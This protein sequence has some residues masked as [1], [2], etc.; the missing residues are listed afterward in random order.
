[1][2][3]L[4]G[5]QVIKAIH[6][7]SDSLKIFDGEIDISKNIVQKDFESIEE[8]T[9]KLNQAKTEL[10]SQEQL[11]E[12]V[13][14]IEKSQNEL[15]S[16]LT[17]IDTIKLKLQKIKSKPALIKAIEKMKAIITVLNTE[18]E[19]FETDQK[20]ISKKIAQ[21]SNELNDINDEIKKR[22]DRISKLQ[23][24]KR[25]L[26]TFGIA[27]DEFES[28]EDLDLMYNKIKLNQS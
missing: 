26:E 22:E 7:I 25:E 6:K 9:E 1:V 16:I 15:Q 11:L 28:N 12:T 10:K 2:K 18:K 20:A 3:A 23:E 14:D 5:D 8:I 24:N 13:K 17:E 19:Q 21:K 27:P 4:P